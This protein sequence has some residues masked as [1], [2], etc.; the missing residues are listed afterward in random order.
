MNNVHTHAS[1]AV[2]T[3]T[4]INC[5]QNAVILF[6]K[7]LLHNKEEIIDA[8]NSAINLFGYSR[9]EFRSLDIQNLFHELTYKR[10]Q[11]A[12]DLSK[13]SEGYCVG[14]ENR[15]FPVEFYSNCIEQDDDTY[16]LVIKDI[17]EKKESEKQLSRYLEELHETKDLM[18]RNAYDLVASNLKLE[19]SQER[20]RE[21]NASK[22]KLFSII[23]HDLRSPFTSF[24][25]LTELLT[26]DYDDMDPLEVKALISELNKSANNV[27]GL[28]ENLLSWSR[29]QTGRMD[30]NPELVSPVDIVDKTA[31]LFEGPAKQKKILLTSQIYSRNNIYADVNMIETIL[32]NL[33]SN[34]IKFTR[35]NGEIIITLSGSNES[36]EFS[37]TDT[38]VGMD[39]ESLSKLFRIDNTHSTHGTNNEVGSGLGLILCKDLIERNKGSIKVESSPGAGT[40][41]SFTIPAK[42]PSKRE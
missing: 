32:R 21:L 27:F 19:D 37:V 33:V 42:A 18:E 5:F 36:V 34:A 23:A 2:N 4:L 24:I 13:M 14:K 25:G 26:E 9:A 17:T 30:F 31:S 29:L 7:D 20:L 8:N 16:L 40:K 12:K 1:A 41:F 39:K 6:K 35:E 11:G 28:L 38:G 3:T 10:I 22:D 15:V